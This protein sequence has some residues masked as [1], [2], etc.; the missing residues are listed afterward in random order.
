MQEKKEKKMI[1]KEYY[2]SFLEASKSWV[3]VLYINRDRTSPE[4]FAFIRYMSQSAMA[5]YS[6]H[7]VIKKEKETD[8]PK[9]IYNFYADLIVSKLK[10]AI[11]TE[12]PRDSVL[13]ISSLLFEDFKDVFFRLS[14]M[15]EEEFAKV[16]GC[17]LFYF[18]LKAF[19]FFDMTF[20]SDRPK[21]FFCRYKS[22]VEVR[23]QFCGHLQKL[24][25]CISGLTEINQAMSTEAGEKKNI[26]RH[27]NDVQELMVRLPLRNLVDS[28]NSFHPEM[29]NYDMDQGEV[30]SAIF[31]PEFD[32][33]SFA[34][35]PLSR[36]YSYIV[37][38]C[39]KILKASFKYIKK[40]NNTLFIQKF[41]LKFEDYLKRL[42]EI[43]EMSAGAGSVD[44][45]KIMNL[46]LENDYQFIEKFIMAE[47]MVYDNKGGISDISDKFKSPALYEGLPK[48]RSTDR[49]IDT[50]RLKDIALNYIYDPA[51]LNRIR[52]PW[53]FE[54]LILKAPIEDIQYLAEMVAG[55]IPVEY[56]EKPI[57][58]ILRSGSFMAYLYNIVT[59]NSGKIMH[60]K[61]SP[62]VS[63]VPWSVRL[64]VE[65]KA[66]C[67]S[68]LIFDESF[69][70]GF[71]SDI[72]KEYLCRKKETDKFRPCLFSLAR[73]LDYQAE[74]Y[75]Y[76]FCFLY[77][78]DYHGMQTL[79]REM[80]R[81]SSRFTAPGQDIPACLNIKDYLETIPV[82]IKDRKVF[83]KHVKE[84]VTVGNQDQERYDIL[85]LFTS[86]DA[87]F[88][89]ARYFY[90]NIIEKIEKTDKKKFYLIYG[91]DYAYVIGLA[92]AL[93]SKAN[94]HADNIMDW[95]ISSSAPEGDD[96]FRVFLDI[97]IF[98][99]KT[100]LMKANEQVFDITCVIAFN[101]GALKR[102]GIENKMG[103]FAGIIEHNVEDR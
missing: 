60:F 11:F 16:K 43:L 31:A 20:W 72:L 28:V 95:N 25:N 89:V 53:K 50:D 13:D 9:R 74:T 76:E 29:L 91:S 39:L 2:D 97:E 81:V 17:D 35:D 100:L 61:P 86:A 65:Q 38:K 98:T 82:K 6:F 75:P 33:G 66:M 18:Y 46:L 1:G 73:V 5:F 92:I 30:Y 77:S 96:V 79:S 24:T 42:K 54:N 67:M 102:P 49:D 101:A 70:S 19:C 80:I 85:R 40:E 4:W 34:F 21:V 94:E 83:K 51:Y 57:I 36:Y 103:T 27:I 69:K 78:W 23:K 22:N 90:E 15:N 3:P 58:G 63:I 45:T 37:W 56:R 12:N 41:T 8:C 87:F 68:P 47:V 10:K 99:G 93:I 7:S 55:M 26:Y 71:T 44:V 62:F 88:A 59:G 84:M 64:P 32:V 52:G 48:K 14:S